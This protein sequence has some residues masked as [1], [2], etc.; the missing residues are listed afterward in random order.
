MVSA[1]TVTSCWRPLW[2]VTFS[3][4]IEQSTLISFKSLLHAAL[5][6][7][8]G[9]LLLLNFPVFERTYYWA[10]CHQIFESLRLSTAITRSVWQQDNIAHVSWP[11]AI[12][13]AQS[14]TFLVSSKNVVSLW[15]PKDIFTWCFCTLLEVPHCS[16]HCQ[17]QDCFP[18]ECHCVQP[19]SWETD[20]SCN[21]LNTIS[22]SS[23]WQNQMNASFL[24]VGS[25]SRSR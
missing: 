16:S 3:L 17:L 7:E 14:I 24:F 10:T 15:L 9:H 22:S 13:S 5:P 25:A 6:S 11:C 21:I 20:R 12:T 19:N 4:R 1:N 18:V 23:I 8:W 2:V